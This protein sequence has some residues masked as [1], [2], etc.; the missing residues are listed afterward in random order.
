VHQTSTG[1]REASGWTRVFRHS[2]GRR[3]GCHHAHCGR[4][5]MSESCSNQDASVAGI[6]S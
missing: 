2:G 4:R 1:P 6:Q 5:G 3:C